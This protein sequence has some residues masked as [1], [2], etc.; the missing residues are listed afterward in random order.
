LGT[1]KRIVV[2]A[3]PSDAHQKHINE[4]ANLE[5]TAFDKKYM[6]MMVS[7]HQKDI[8]IYEQAANNSKM[9]AEVKAFA[10]KILPTLRQHLQ[11]AQNVNRT[12]R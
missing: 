4:L 5:G 8:Q 9:D 11:M 10:V 7:D 2:P 12:V 1:A 6:D 3:S